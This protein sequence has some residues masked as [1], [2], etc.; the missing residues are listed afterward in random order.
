MENLLSRAR[1]FPFSFNFFECVFFQPRKAPT[2]KTYSLAPA[3]FLLLLKNGKRAGG[4][5]ANIQEQER[6]L[7]ARA[8][9]AR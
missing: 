2:R 4:E 5:S 9:R 8:R 7:R 1:A 6:E 3:L